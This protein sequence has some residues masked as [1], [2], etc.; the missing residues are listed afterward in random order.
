MSLITGH[1][2]HV[3]DQPVIGYGTDSAAASQGFPQPPLA[4]TE[5]RIDLWTSIV[6]YATL[7]ITAGHLVDPDRIR[8]ALG[9]LTLLSEQQGI[10]TPDQ[11][12]LRAYGDLPSPATRG[13]LIAQ[14]ADPVYLGHLDEGLLDENGDPWNGVE[15]LRLESERVAVFR[16]GDAETERVFWDGAFSSLG[17][18]RILLD[19]EDPALPRLARRF[20]HFE[21]CPLLLSDLTDRRPRITVG[22][23]HMDDAY[24]CLYHSGIQPPSPPNRLGFFL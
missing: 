11:A 21:D 1:P 6:L 17:H 13:K 12:R 4:P 3:C 14:L 10:P 8:H 22:R 15:I 7:R 2:I 24:L 18:G 9:D 19:L 23:C 16:L 5:I 20:E